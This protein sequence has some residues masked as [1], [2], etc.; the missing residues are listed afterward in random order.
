MREIKTK[1][2]FQNYFFTF[3][4]VSETEKVFPEKQAKLGLKKEAK[5]KERRMMKNDHRLLFS[6]ATPQDDSS[7][8]QFTT[9]GKSLQR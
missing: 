5:I 3:F 8:S 9:L 7:R 6:S 1:T 4:V 2:L